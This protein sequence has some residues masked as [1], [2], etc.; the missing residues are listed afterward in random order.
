MHERLRE[1]R[2]ALGLTQK[3]FGEK[4]GLQ[5]SSIATYESGRNKPSGAA[6]KQIC[7]RFRVNERWLRTGEGE[8]FVPCSPDEELSEALEKILLAE[9]SDFKK[10]FFA[11]LLRMDDAGWKAL[12]ALVEAL[13][14]DPGDSRPVEQ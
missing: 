4:I 8:M 12:E 2:L 1:L 3:A 13:K 5:N 11:A 6:I 9:P 7:D 10:R 14:N